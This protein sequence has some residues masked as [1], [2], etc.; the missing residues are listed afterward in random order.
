MSTY[1]IDDTSKGIFTTNFYIVANFDYFI[2]FCTI[3]GESIF[4]FVDLK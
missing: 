4:A 1:L 2:S 3:D